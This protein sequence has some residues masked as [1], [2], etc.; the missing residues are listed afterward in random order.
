MAEETNLEIGKEIGYHVRFEKSKYSSENKIKFMTDGILLNEMM[1]DFLLSKYSVVIIDEAHERKLATDILLGLLSRVIKIRADKCLEQF[2]MANRKED[3]TIFPLRLIIMS[4]TLKIKDFLENKR[5]F[6]MTPP[7]V[8]IEVRNFPVNVFYNKITPEDYFEEMITKVKKIHLNLPKGGI[9]VFLTG[10]EE[11]NKFCRELH[12]EMKYIKK[13][14]APKEEDLLNGKIDLENIEMIKDK[15]EAEDD[16]KSNSIEEFEFLENSLKKT[17]DKKQNYYITPTYQIFPLYSKL[18][19]EQQQKIFNSNPEKRLII[20]STNVAETS[21]TINGLKYLVDSGKE[22]NK[23]IDLKTGV[24]KYSI[25]FT[26]KSSAEQRK[27]RVGRTG[28]GYCYRIY[29][30]A[31]YKRMKKH[32]KPEILRL[33]LNYSILQLAKIGME[34]I[35]DFPFPSLPDEKVIKNGIVDLID[36]GLLKRKNNH[37]KKVEITK[38]GE[39][40]SFIPLQPHFSIILL[41]MKKESLLHLGILLVGILSSEELFNFGNI[42]L[43]KEEKFKYFQQYDDFL[44]SSSD[45]LTI[46]NIV[47]T[48][49][50]QL[51]NKFFNN[52][53]NI[54][55][56]QISNRISEFATKMNLNLKVFKEFLN[57]IIQVVIIFKYLLNE[58]D[59][60]NILEKLQ[61][62]TNVTKK[63]ERILIKIISESFKNNITKKRI[64][65]VDD[66][67]TKLRFETLDF[68]EAK[69]FKNSFVKKNNMF[70]IYQTILEIDG[71]YFL[72]NIT[73][74]Q[75]YSILINL[76]K[77]RIK[78]IYL[79][80]R[81]IFDN[82]YETFYDK[83]NDKVLSYYKYYFGPF[84]WETPVFLY[85]CEFDNENKYALFLIC[86]LK[87]QIFLKIKQVTQFYKFKINKINENF[88]KTNPTLVKFIK[89]FKEFDIFNKKS[90]LHF[91]DKAIFKKLFI[92]FFERKKQNKISFIFDKLFN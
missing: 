63:E 88:I 83:K 78:N 1:S 75:D 48:F 57:F 46:L 4:A 72:K 13:I 66:N 59:Y 28:V 35:Q 6:P 67:R 26:T 45:I 34:N 87:G 2:R 60:K 22:K 51:D 20:I 11:V 70:Y 31:V 69:F 29:S 15:D 58:I 49:F 3:I 54:K 23:Y 10:K 25:D 24:T 19:V 18:P 42:N 64:V 50:I 44:N 12:Q 14:E 76:D 37:L 55:K 38:L 8:N 39:T 40:L 5:L 84:K 85:D 62:F 77:K 53:Q 80:K 81:L 73:K 74:I 82:N 21:L 30:P 9:L 52:F 90:F 27:G 36:M 56:I 32:K 43:S 7:L 86:F 92:E 47:G 68:R 17:E 91:Q 65:V 16:D 61:N 79:E 41:K 89:K 71:K 33:P